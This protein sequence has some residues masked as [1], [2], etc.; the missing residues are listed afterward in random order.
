M[1]ALIPREGSAPVRDRLLMTLF[2]AALIHGM[3]ILGLT[4]AGSGG[5]ES[6][7]HGLDVLLVSDELPTAA[8]NDSAAYLAQRTQLGSGNTSAPTAAHNQATAASP[9]PHAGEDAGTSLASSAPAA[10]RA[11]DQVLTTIATRT[12][13]RYFAAPGDAGTNR[14]RPAANATTAAPRPADSENGTVQL[15]G[16]KRDELWITP[17]TRESIIAPYLDSWRQRVERIGTLNYPTAALHSG[18]RASPV[19][20]VAI[21][22]DGRLAKAEILTSSG[23][24]DLDAAALAILKL[25][26]PFDPF[27]PDLAAR[28]HTLRF[29][30]EWQFTGGHLAAGTV[31]TVP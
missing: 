17:D 4:F 28:Y 21:D 26:S 6:G 8:R 25:A 14:D 27:P 29:A 20:E 5:T 12:D 22:A 10:A 1:R 3:I 16:A 23:F 13:I 31:S 7:G 24:A 9:P 15:R 11:D 30:Y 18:V 19:L 2:I